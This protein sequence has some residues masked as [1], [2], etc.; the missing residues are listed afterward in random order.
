M[1]LTFFIAFNFQ[2]IDNKN[3]NS[4]IT[5]IP[6]SNKNVST[7]YQDPHNKDLGIGP[8]KKVE[9]GPINSKMVDEGK[10]LFNTKCS[11]CHEMNQKKIG[12]PLGDVTKQRTPE[13]IMNL[14]LNTVQMQKDDG[15][16]KELLNEYNNLPMPNPALTQDQARAI[17]EYLR[18]VAK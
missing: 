5:S 17:L 10:A 8:V 11:I 18:S 3:S 1:V 14:L 9:L 7:S 6:V 13:F 16:M 2:L 12:P 4:A 15:T